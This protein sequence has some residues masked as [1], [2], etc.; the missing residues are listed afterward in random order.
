MRGRRSRPP[1]ARLA[2]G[3][4][5]ARGDS[6]ACRH[7]TPSTSLNGAAAPIETLAIARWLSYHEATRRRRVAD[8]EFTSPLLRPPRG[9]VPPILKQS[10]RTSHMRIVSRLILLM[11]LLA[12]PSLCQGQEWTRFRGP[13]GQGAV[14]TLVLPAEFS[15]ADFNWRVELPGVGHSS[16]AIWGERIFLLSADPETA[17]RHM[18]CLHADDGRELWRRS[19]AS[20]TH[21]LHVRSSYASCSPAVDEERVYVAWSSPEH[22]VFKAFTHDGKEVWSR[23]LGRWVS[24]HGWGSS[25]MVYEDL[26]IVSN[27]QQ[28]NQ[29]KEGE[30]PGESRIMAFNRTTGETVWTTPRVSVNVCY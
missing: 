13:N 18:L 29:L 17:E 5:G 24:Q 14:D 2:S 30:V 28:A 20:E 11:L 1:L 8:D 26:V 9:S 19:F 25:P 7:A 10:L 6:R 23:D 12:S 27:S 15:E 3:R 22:T 16:P 4:P 21:H